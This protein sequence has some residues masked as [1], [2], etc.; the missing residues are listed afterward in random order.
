MTPEQLYLVAYLFALNDILN[1]MIA[2]EQAV[3]QDLR[4]LLDLQQNP[5]VV[6]GPC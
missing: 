6:P 5:V 1:R 4:R 2:R 3:Q